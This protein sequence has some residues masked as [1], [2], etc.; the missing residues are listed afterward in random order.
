MELH[1]WN[2]SSNPAGPDR[3]D[4]SRMEL[5]TLLADIFSI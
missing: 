4:V 5:F 2:S 1:I 3:T